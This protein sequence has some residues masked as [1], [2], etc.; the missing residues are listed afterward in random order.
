MAASSGAQFF[1]SGHRMLQDN[2]RGGGGRGDDGRRWEVTGGHYL[3]YS[4]CCRCSRLCLWG[5]S[6]IT[7]A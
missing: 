3:M 6:D 7:S 5:S 2:V 4:N 1:D